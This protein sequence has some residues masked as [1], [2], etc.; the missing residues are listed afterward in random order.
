MEEETQQ[1][2]SPFEDLEVN[3]M[4]VGVELYKALNLSRAEF[5]DGTQTAKLK[6]IAEFLNNHPDPVF[7]IRSVIRS[8][9]NPN[10]K[11]IDHL[12]TYVQLNNK[13]RDLENRI[14]KLNNELKYYE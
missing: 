5:A 9:K 1:Y 13:K 6:D 12:W 2:N 14:N 3:D 10:I 7:I 4:E 11:N 8:N